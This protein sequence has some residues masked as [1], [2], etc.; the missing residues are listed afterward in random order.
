MTNNQSGPRTRPSAGVAGTSSTV[1]REGQTFVHRTRDGRG[2]GSAGHVFRT[3]LPEGPVLG[4][5]RCR[6]ARNR[7]SRQSSAATGP[8]S[9]S[10]LTNP[11]VLATF[12]ISGLNTH[13]D[14][15]TMGIIVTA[16]T[17]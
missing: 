5:Q 16:V 7:V 12:A 11:A 6:D 3:I 8:L 15:R 17:E 14:S 4:G 1:R 2:R 13:A 9:L 10:A